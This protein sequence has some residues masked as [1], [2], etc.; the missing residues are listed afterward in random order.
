M[1]LNI[2]MQEHIIMQSLLSV[3]VTL[4]LSVC[5]SWV[6][7]CG[8]VRMCVHVCTCVYTCK[9]L[10][11]HTHLLFGSS[12]CTELLL[13]SCLDHIHTEHI[14]K[15]T[16]RTTSDGLDIQSSQECTFWFRHFRQLCHSSPRK[17]LL[18]AISL[19]GASLVMAIHVGGAVL[20][21]P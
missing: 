15:Y 11:V 2:K 14:H 9:G 19:C 13:D 17:H 21:L 6:V 1:S 10:A 7:G 3:D 18:Y 16:D 5:V 8:Y 20:L 12:H 4:S